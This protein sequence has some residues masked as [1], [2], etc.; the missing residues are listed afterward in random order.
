MIKLFYYYS[1]KSQKAFPVY[2]PSM[3][4][5]LNNDPNY[6]TDTREGTTV[7]SKSHNKSNIYSEM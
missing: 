7:R 1:V 2:Q 6:V 3:I 4:N 5:V